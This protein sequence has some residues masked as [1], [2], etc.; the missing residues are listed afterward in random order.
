MSF[1]LMKDMGLRDPRIFPRKFMG[2]PRRVW[3]AIQAWGPLP[4]PETS[5]PVQHLEVHADGSAVLST[6]WPVTPV[7]AG[8]GCLVFAIGPD[9]QR[10]C[11]GAVWGPVDTLQS[12]PFVLGARPPT[13]P[14]AELSAITHALRMLRLVAYT[15]TIHWPSDSLYA[16]GIVQGGRGA[17]TELELVTVAR[18]EAS[19][20]VWQWALHGTHTPTHIG[21]PPNE[22]ADVIARMGRLA[23]E[24]S[25]EVQQ[26]LLRVLPLQRFLNNESVSVL[27]RLYSGQSWKARL[28][29]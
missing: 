29:S 19:F 12:S 18:T 3:Q 1:S 26:S 15:G 2:K 27:S 25:E 28:T 6:G 9:A 7:N 20:A 10:A 4:T 8:W 14:V 17:A 24:L 5:F 16:L 21:C 13:I 11:L 22:C 23:A